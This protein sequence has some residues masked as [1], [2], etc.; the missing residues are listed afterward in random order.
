MAS[1]LR[2]VRLWLR[3]LLDRYEAASLYDFYDWTQLRELD[4]A[5]REVQCVFAEIGMVL[6][7]LMQVEHAM[8]AVV[9]AARKTAPGNPAPA[10]HLTFGNARKSL[11]KIVDERC[12]QGLVGPQLAL[13]ER[14]NT[15]RNH[16]VHGEVSVVVGPPDSPHSGDILEIF[17]LDG[18]QS[19]ALDVPAARALAEDALDAVVDVMAALD[20]P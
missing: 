20:L 9:R 3:A 2:P 10:R 18:D 11:R 16:L 12:P 7:Q 17:W 5:E 4:V 1:E 19:D 14:A 15:L 8:N 13:L 6:A